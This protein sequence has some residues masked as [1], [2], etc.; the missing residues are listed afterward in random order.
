M[1]FCLAMTAKYSMTFI[2]D[3]AGKPRKLKHHSD[4]VASKAKYNENISKMV[5]LFGDVFFDL[6]KI[7]DALPC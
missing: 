3:I 5:Q 1:V 6:F 2:R 4:A 7:S